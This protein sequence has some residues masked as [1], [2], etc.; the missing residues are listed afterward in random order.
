[1][2]NRQ[3]PKTAR[4][5]SSEYAQSESRAVFLQEVIIDANDAEAV[6]KYADRFLAAIEQ[7]TLDKLKKPNANYEEIASYYRVASRFTDMLVSAVELGKQK[8]KALEDIARAPK[9]R[10]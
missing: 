10:N 8:A 5:Y 1:M 6:L 4:I 9:R 3:E 2:R 7:E